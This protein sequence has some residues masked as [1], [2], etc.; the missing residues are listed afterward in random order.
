MQTYGDFLNFNPHLHA[1]VSDGCFLGN[2]SFSVAPKF[3]VTDLS[4][5]F[6]YEVLK[7]L[8]KAGKINDV[9]IENMLSWHH[10][11]FQVYIGARIYPSDK[12]GLGNLARYIV[13]ACFSQE[14]MIYIPDKESD[15][16]VAKVVYI[17]KDRK[18]R[19][20]FTALDWLARPVTH[21]PSRYEQTV[22]YYGYYSNKSRGMRKKAGMDDA[23]PALIPTEMSSKSLISLNWFTTIQSPRFRLLIIGVDF[24]KLG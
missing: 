19:K 14:R 2:D 7:M 20:I 22:R 17:S 15:D 16:G 24:F 5:V 3:M 1:I 13:R 23:I 9:I 18:S 8:K 10:S 21:I 12:I 6:Q 11:G 4:R